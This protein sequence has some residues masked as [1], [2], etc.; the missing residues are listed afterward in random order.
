[1]HLDIRARKLLIVAVRDEFQT[2]A[3]GVAQSA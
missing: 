1:M 2:P 3:T